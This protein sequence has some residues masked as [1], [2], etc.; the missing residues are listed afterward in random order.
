MQVLS[1]RLA[2]GM[3][4]GLS[5]SGAVQVT[6][7]RGHQDK[8]RGENVFFFGW[9]FS[10]FFFFHVLYIKSPSLPLSWAHTLTNPFKALFC[11]ELTI[12]WSDD[13]K[14]NVQ[15]FQIKNGSKQHHW[16]KRSAAS[17][18][19]FFFCNQCV[20]CW[21]RVATWSHCLEKKQRPSVK[22][23]GADGRRPEID[24]SNCLLPEEK[25]LQTEGSQCS[26]QTRKK[27]IRAFF[28]VGGLL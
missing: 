4:G 22:F 7:A 21:P 15:G 16:E 1:G 6:P 5:S 2:E 25:H 17:F 13:I 10:G 28:G 27:L 11:F 26:Q 18:F 3:K 20:L 12:H 8:F 23:F 9:W 24:H 14:E 19:C